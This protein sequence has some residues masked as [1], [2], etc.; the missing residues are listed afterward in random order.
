MYFLISLVIM[1][2]LLIFEPQFFWI[3]LPFVLTYAVVALDKM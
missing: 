2:L 1:I 3:P